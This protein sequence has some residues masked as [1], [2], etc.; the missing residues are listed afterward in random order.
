M[1]VYSSAFVF[2]LQQ[3]NCM[4]YPGVLCMI[5]RAISLCL[6]HTLKMPVVLMMEIDRYLA[7]TLC[8][9]SPAFQGNASS[10]RNPHC[11]SHPNTLQWYCPVC[12]LSGILLTLRD[13]LR[14]WFLPCECMLINGCQPTSSFTHTP[15]TEWRMLAVNRTSQRVGLLLVF[16][17]F[18]ASL[19]SR[20]SRK[21]WQTKWDGKHGSG[22]VQSSVFGSPE[23]CHLTLCL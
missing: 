17:D 19:W 1:T 16:Y 20:A 21:R 8:H 23:G 11:C 14:H 3:V 13:W 6:L 15:G 4:G 2:C 10:G 12:H 9:V 5:N 22:M 7:I 18:S